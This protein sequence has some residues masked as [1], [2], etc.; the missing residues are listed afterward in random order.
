MNDNPTNQPV[1]LI[2]GASAG[3]GLA[4]AGFLAAQ[5]YNLI[6]TGRND[7]RLQG[8]VYEL[9]RRGG[10]VEGIAGDAASPAHQRRLAEAVAGRGRLDLLVNNASTLGPRPMPALPDYPLDALRQVLEINTVA[11]L[12]LVQALQPWLAETR[13]LVVNITSDAALG[14]YPGWGGYGASKAALELLSLTLANELR[15]EGIAAVAVDPGDMRTQ[16]QQDA[17]PDEDISDRP[18]PDVTLP[19]WAWLLGQAPAAVSGQRFQAQGEQWQV[20]V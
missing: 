10:R 14:G 5:D 2:T 18:L 4:L 19:F 8:A 12:A 11:P 20:A 13:G 16:M 1:A 3:L 9:R 17:F 15:D 6:V 7:R